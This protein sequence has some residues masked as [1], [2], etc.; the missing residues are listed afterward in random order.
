[1]LVWRGSSTPDPASGEPP[2][3]GIAHPIGAPSREPIARPGGWGRGR[4]IRAHPLVGTVLEGERALRSRAQC[5]AKGSRAD[6]HTSGTGRGRRETPAFVPCSGTTAR[7]P[8]RSG[9]AMRSAARRSVTRR[10]LALRSPMTCSRTCSGTVR[11]TSRTPIV[12][13][14]L[15]A[16]AGG[17]SAS[18]NWA[19]IVHPVHRAK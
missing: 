7:H 6:L 18:P 16:V 11:R 3:L 5:L 12:V 17:L 10:G 2:N 15:E 1:M 9:C 13:L 4:R 8:D 19:D 14:R